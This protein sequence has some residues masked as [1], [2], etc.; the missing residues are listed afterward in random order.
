MIVPHLVP[1]KM[2]NDA[3]GPGS[4]APVPFLQVF[5]PSLPAGMGQNAPN[6]AIT[7]S[8][9]G[10]DLPLYGPMVTPSFQV[11]AWAQ[12]AKDAAAL[13]LRALGVLHDCGDIVVS[14]ID[15]DARVLFGRADGW[16]QD[17]TD[18]ET[19]WD[20]NVCFVS[21]GMIL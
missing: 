3:L 6:A 18:Q 12:N 21:L 5:A 20:T 19:G 7:V 2:L 15:G 8:V 9:R 17:V 13:M 14:T 4:A 10:G 11:I 16:P 1:V